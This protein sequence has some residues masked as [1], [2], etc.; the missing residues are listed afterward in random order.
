VWGDLGSENDRAEEGEGVSA[1]IHT[2]D[3]CRA[4]R[5]PRAGA[6]RALTALGVTVGLKLRGFLGSQRWRLELHVG[7]VAALGASDRQIGGSTTRPGSVRDAAALEKEL[8]VNV[9]VETDADSDSSGLT[10]AAQDKKSC[11]GQCRCGHQKFR[12]HLQWIIAGGQNRSCQVGLNFT[13]NA[14]ALD[15]V[16]KARDERVNRLGPVTSLDSCSQDEGGSRR[17]PDRSATDRC[18]RGCSESMSSVYHDPR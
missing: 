18:N 12:S 3:L 11:Q 5:D 2:D 17:C 13:C 7:A 16:P 14:A 6:P 1:L 15:D 10:G 9:T 8:D 4:D